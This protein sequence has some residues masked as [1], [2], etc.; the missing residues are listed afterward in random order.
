MPYVICVEVDE[1]GN[2]AAGK[3]SGKGELPTSASWL[4]TSVSR[5]S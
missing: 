2:A 4:A 5:L 3:E 1:Q